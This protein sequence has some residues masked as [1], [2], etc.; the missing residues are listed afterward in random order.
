LAQDPI[1]VELLEMNT[2]ISKVYAPTGQFTPL[3]VDIL[4]R[5]KN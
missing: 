5:D 2:F 3:T 1:E 4:I